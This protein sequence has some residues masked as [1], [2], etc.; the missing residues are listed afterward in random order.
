[1]TVCH[2]HSF[3][4]WNM[5]TSS[6][7]FKYHTSTFVAFLH[8]FF[9]QNAIVDCKVAHKRKIAN[10]VG[11]FEK[12]N[13]RRQS[14]Q[15][16][17]HLLK[18]KTENRGGILLLKFRFHITLKFAMHIFHEW[19]FRRGWTLVFKGKIQHTVLEIFWTDVLLLLCKNLQK[20]WKLFEIFIF[21]QVKDIST[22][23]VIL[24]EEEDPSRKSVKKILKWRVGSIFCDN[25]SELQ[26]II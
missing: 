3:I 11:S 25:L 12:K 15:N 22:N 24:T 20:F 6:L 1:M 13:E 16:E 4:H 9:W 17:S 21:N 23:F 10:I 18:G 7:S 5:L 19:L 14:L 2:K 8:I 26:K